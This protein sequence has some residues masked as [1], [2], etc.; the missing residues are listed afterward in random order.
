MSASPF[1]AKAALRVIAASRPE[2]AA[3]PGANWRAGLICKKNG[4]PKALHLNVLRALLEAPELAGMVSFDAFKLKVTIERTTPW[5]SQAGQTWTEDDDLKLAIWCQSKGIEVRPDVAGPVLQTV[6]RERPRHAVRNYL[7]ALQWDGVRRIDGWLHLYLGVDQSPYACAV[8]ARWLIS[9]VAR[10]MEPGCKVDT[11]LILEGPQ[12]IGKSRALKVLAG[13]EWFS[14]SPIEINSKDGAIMLAGK[15]IV[16]FAEL[17]TLDR[18]TSART[19]AYM[20]SA[21]D[22]YRPPYAKTNKDHKR[23][24]VFAGTVNESTYLKDATGGRRFWPVKCGESLDLTGLERDRDQLWSEAVARYN[25]G[26]PWWLEEQKLVQ[27]A[28][29]EQANRFEAHPWEPIIAKWLNINETMT[30]VT[31]PQILDSCIDKPKER[32]TQP[33]Q[34]N[35]ARCLQAL[36]W[37]RYRFRHDGKLVW[38]YRPKAGK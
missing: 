36:G 12:G 14:D 13:E 11:C 22:N 23:Q 15:W 18:A 32:W 30:T 34:N 33:D 9:A 4:D 24:C 7:D 2:A 25:A 6:A 1:T 16:E 37:E 38:G 28:A 29:E 5:G 21:T 20:S 26:A 35:V 27:A 3:D 17:D 10:I 8:G 19:K 31:I